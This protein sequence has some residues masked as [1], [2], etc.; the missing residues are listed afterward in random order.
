M[1][2][3]MMNNTINL[4]ADNI[5]SYE[6]NF[7]LQ[8]IYFKRLV[9]L[10]FALNNKKIDLER[11]KNCQR[12]IKEKT[13]LL[14][15]FRTY[16][17][18]LLSG[19]LVLDGDEDKTFVSIL[20]VYKDL[21]AKKFKSFYLPLLCYLLVKYSDFISLNSSIKKT[22]T[23]YFGMKKKH[24]F[25][26]MPRKYIL[27]GLLALSELDSDLLLKK[28]EKHYQSLKKVLST[29]STLLEVC[30]ILSLSEDLFDI[31]R[32]L[33]GF[34]EKFKAKG[35]K[36][37]RRYVMLSLGML[38]LLPEGADEIADQVESVYQ[39][40]LKYKLFNNFLI[41]K[42]EVL[43]YA[44]GI[45]AWSYAEATN[46]ELSLTVDLKALIISVLILSVGTFAE[47]SRNTN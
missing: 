31:E 21:K 30:N 9:A 14:S 19:L 1:T 35:L 41:S 38:A 27:A 47:E 23:L 13:S 6:K 12:I 36:L 26:T 32:K 44:S 10:L 34:F 16:F 46:Q 15:P 22:E 33:L 20:D 37:I 5:I 11:I 45:V 3:E 39:E 18:F 2:E 25:L 4:F 8:N 29:R 7:S 40:L 17:N 24:P 28:S 42:Q 43:V